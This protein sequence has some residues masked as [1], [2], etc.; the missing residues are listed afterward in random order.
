M[1]ECT[2]STSWPIGAAPQ[3]VNFSALMSKVFN[4]DSVASV[5]VTLS[6]LSLASIAKCSRESH[7][8]CGLALCTSSV[9]GSKLPKGDYA[10]CF[11][12]LAR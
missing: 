4:L 7:A 8:C 10:C 11:A 6:G 5:P 3:S 9:E 12:Q 1:L 2:T